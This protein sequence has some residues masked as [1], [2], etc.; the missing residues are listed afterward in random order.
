MF[1]FSLHALK[2]H[3]VSL[4]YQ[5]DPAPIRTYARPSG[6]T[7]VRP[8]CLKLT[9]MN[10]RLCFI[11]VL[12]FS[13]LDGDRYLYGCHRKCH[14]ETMQ[15]ILS[16]QRERKL[17]WIEI[18]QIGLFQKKITFLVRKFPKF[19]VWFFTLYAFIIC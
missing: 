2:S 4:Y 1:V 5:I 18:T 15:N 6:C 17:L 12:K 9:A 14:N 13:C 3:M 8:Q 16:I 11:I 10:I 7:C 19:C